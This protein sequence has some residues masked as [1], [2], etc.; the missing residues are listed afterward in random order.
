M[1]VCS[2]K[3][4]CELFLGEDQLEVLQVNVSEVIIPL[5][6]V[7]IPMSSQCV[8]FC[9]EFS[10]A[11]SD[12]QVE[13]TKILTIRPV[14][15]SEFSWLRS[16]PDFCGQSPHQLGFQNLQGNDAKIE[17]LHILPETLCCGCHS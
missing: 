7:D 5:F 9:S 13:L 6:G 2:L 17:K 14:S 11:E 3:G 8:G 10:R 15:M 1:E 12:N 16:T 4:Q